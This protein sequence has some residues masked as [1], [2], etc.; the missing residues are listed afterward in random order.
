MTRAAARTIFIAIVTISVLTLISYTH[1]LLTRFEFYR[2][3][4]RR[5]PWYMVE[6]IDK[7]LG[8]LICATAIHILFRR[9]P[10]PVVNELALTRSPAV[11]FGFALLATSP[12]LVGF[13][14]TR[15]IALDSNPPEL[16]FLTLFSPLVEEI[17]YRG[18]GFRQLMLRAGW[19]F[20]FAVIPPAVLFGQGHIEKGASLQDMT[21]LFLIT[22]IG[23]VTFSWLLY[24][25]Q[26][27]WVPIACHILMNLWW[28]LFSVSRSAIG[29]WF[30]F[31]LQAAS[32]TA[33]ILLT[34]L[35]TNAPATQFAN[36]V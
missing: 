17:E 6:S 29:G 23:A 11:G 7:L 4:H 9:G 20:W 15:R 36:A 32:V 13:A 8:L 19:P 30:P 10:I 16:I 28:A 12:M 14:A 35:W 21:E 34:L 31:A 33:A 22:A 26:N 1:E 5:H 2:S 24:R 25:W 18:Y 27:L 3:L